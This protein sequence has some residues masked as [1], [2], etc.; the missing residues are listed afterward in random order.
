MTPYVGEWSSP[1][2][3]SI[4]F[5]DAPPVDDGDDGG[6]SLSQPPVDVSGDAVHQ[7]FDDLNAQTHL[8]AGLNDMYGSIFPDH[9]PF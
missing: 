2:A 8:Q 7:A 5:V 9:T 4:P 3:E 1:G 6:Q